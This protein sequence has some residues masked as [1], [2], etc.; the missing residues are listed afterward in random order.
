M[1]Q[2]HDGYLWFGTEHGLARFDGIHFTVFDHANTP[3]LAHNI[4]G[5]LYEDHHGVLWI[6]TLGGG[7]TR[8]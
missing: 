2:T 5:R 7:L 3:A 6:S 8:Y 1:T 4:I